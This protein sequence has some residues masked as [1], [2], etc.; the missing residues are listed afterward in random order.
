MCVCPNAR[1]SQS[2]FAR[3]VQTVHNH[4]DCRARTG[5][6]IWDQGVCETVPFDIV[7]QVAIAA[8]ASDI[9]HMMRQGFNFVQGS[10]W[11]MTAGGYMY[12]KQ[13]EH[14]MRAHLD[15]VGASKDGADNFPRNNR[16]Q[17]SALVVFAPS[18]VE[19][20]GVA[21]L[22]VSQLTRRLSAMR[23]LSF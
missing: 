6:A 18:Y 13:S 10:S 8:G 14:H 7:R 5:T 4:P 19:K 23:R 22:P 15:S 3:I 21:A 17:A 9:G 12:L 11:Q 20:S 2:L 16:F 1:E